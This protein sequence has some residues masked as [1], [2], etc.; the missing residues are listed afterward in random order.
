MSGALVA[1]INEDMKLVAA[2]AFQPGLDELPLLFV[3]FDV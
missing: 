2:I 1:A 3:F